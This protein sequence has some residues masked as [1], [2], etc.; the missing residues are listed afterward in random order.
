MGIRVAG[1][2]KEFGS[3]RAVDNVSLD[4]D[5]GSLVALLGP[6]G[7]GKSTLLRLIAGLEEADAGRVWIT[8]E[9]A[10]SRSVQ[11]RQVGFV[12]QH[13]ALF[14]HRTVR[15][16]VGFGLELRG[17]QHDAIR[18]RVDELLELV[19]LQGYGSRYPSQLSGGQRQRVALA[20]ALAVQ[21]RV[22]LLDEPFS[23]L[24]AKVRKELRA[25]LRNL[26]DEMHVTTVIVT[27]DQEE[28]ME[29]AD[30]IVVMNEGRIEQIGS[31]AEI[32]DQPAS[33]FVMSFVGA[34]NVLPPHVA[35]APNRE[36]RGELFIRP[37]DLELH[38]DPQEGSV[39]AVLRRLTHLGR[40]IQAELTL[41]S[42]EVVVAQ[43]PR[44]RIDYRELQAGD[45]LHITS[46]DSRTFVPV[47]VI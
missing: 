21:P 31:P 39:P 41:A 4:V 2:C 25:W 10:T 28:A 6:S 8:G 16:N 15:Q 7:S 12:F 22:L 37:H 20:R 14:K 17:W 18:R 29:V 30:K 27:H 42:G 45:A 38:R 44:E 19:Q 1:V 34:V 5:T 46:R 33:P 36:R 9:E 32:Y 47:F 24:D 43:L 35:L 23:A 11:E 13:F 26:H 40:D 3:F